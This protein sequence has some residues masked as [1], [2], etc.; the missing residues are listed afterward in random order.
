MSI[1]RGTNSGI[2]GPKQRV[3]CPGQL[4]FGKLFALFNLDSDSFGPFRGP[5]IFC[6]RDLQQMFLVILN[7]FLSGGEYLDW[8]G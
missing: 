1:S 6:F 5:W 4:G 3:R 2:S 8:P 7:G